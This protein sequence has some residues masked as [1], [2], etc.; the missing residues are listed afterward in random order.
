[1]KN[2]IIIVTMISLVFLII[3]QANAESVPDWV[4]NTAGWWSTDAISE[5]EFVNAIE[6][7]VND[8][9]IQVSVSEYAGT[10]NGVP[11]WVKNT[12]GWWSTDAISEKEFVNAIEFL[13]KSGIINIESDLTCQK[14]LET[15]SSNLNKINIACE[16]YYSDKTSELIPYESV[17]SNLN[18]K[19]F[20]GEEF[21]IKKP[22]DE[23]RVFVLGDSVIQGSGNSSP[24][25][26][27]P[28]ILQKMIVNNNNESTANVINAA[29]GGGL[30]DYQAEMIKT[31][32]PEYEPDVVILYTGW[33]ELSRDYPVMGIIDFLRGVCNTDRQ[34]NFDIMIVLQPIAGFGNKV[35]TE[36]E[37]INSLT[38]QDHNGFQLLQAR[39]T[40]DW[41]EK[42]IQILIKNSDNNA[43]TFHDLR[44]TFDDISGPIYWDQGHVSDTG[45]L[46]LAD[47]FL[48]ELS[49]TYPNTF[50]YNEK[51]YNIIKDYNHP[52]ITELIIS[53]LGINV[54]YSNVSYKDVTNFSDPKGNYFDLKENSGIE[55]ILVGND[56]RN[57]NLNTISLNG[58]DLT[59]ANLSGQDLREID[60]AST[61]IR[62]ADLSYTNLEGKDL[63][64]M[65]LRGINFMGAN[66][67]DV[68]FTDAIF[69]K[70]IQIFECGNDEDKRLNLFK[71]FKC[72]STVVKN[73][74]I[75]TDFTNANL[76]NAEFGIK[77][78]KEYQK[79]FFADFTNANMTDVSLNDI[80][81]AG[82]NFTDAELNGV[83]GKQIFIVDSDF[84]NAE[85]KNFKISETWLQSTSFYNAD[86]I[87]GA[88]DSM[89]FTDVDF[90]ETDFQ[91]TE[92]TIIIEI[93]DS[94]NY[95]CKNNIIC[96]LK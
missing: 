37:K 81:F 80:Q 33:N 67:K 1:M 26:T 53:E 78:I 34:N 38:G 7:L 18:K 89:I 69:S 49:K 93:G 51:F 61:I 90:T 87:N 9:I 70:P 64:K 28:Y 50:S 92:F 22:N 63:S 73:E 20:V 17:S 23:F 16:D 85:M 47:R 95:N 59:G 56:L 72:V 79:V 42:E 25:T 54:D 84:T 77:E 11:D 62:G 8:K 40:Y 46:I 2:K 74:G 75:R 45:N 13:I 76:I 58:K 24:H 10:S 43:C 14:D 36:Q 48:K 29:G 19:G 60:I 71:N 65:D 86:M 83:S 12:A 4:K 30:V 3:P 15:F 44:N 5:K 68:N 52:S 6:F 41:L 94:N 88:F 27:A 57:V 66:L 21:P 31:I 39:S 55:G 96:N 91:G 35:L 82:G 32:L